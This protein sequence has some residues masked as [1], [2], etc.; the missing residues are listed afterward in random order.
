MIQELL[1]PIITEK[2]FYNLV[3]FYIM[4]LYD[5]HQIAYFLFN[6]T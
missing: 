3:F 5:K 2:Y 4:T 1:I 6:L